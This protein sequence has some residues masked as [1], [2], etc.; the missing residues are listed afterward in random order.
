ME[1][2]RIVPLGGIPDLGMPRRVHVGF[3]PF[4]PKGEGLWRSAGGPA[5][6]RDRGLPRSLELAAPAPPKSRSGPETGPEALLLLGAFGLHAGSETPDAVGATV[7]L[8]RGT[9]LVRSFPLRNGVHYADADDRALRSVLPGDGSEVKTVG[10]CLVDGRM[11]RVDLLTI[12]LPAGTEFDRVVFH[13]EGGVSSFAIL[14]AA[15]VWEE[16][17][18][19][20]FRAGAG[21][22]SLADLGSVVRVRDRVRFGKALDQLESSLR[23]SEDL[24]EARSEALTFIAVVTAGRLESGA[25]RSLHRTQLDAARRFEAVASVEAL[26]D[27]ARE[28]LRSLVPELLS[29]EESAQDRQID[30]ALAILARSFAGPLSDEAV[31]GQVGLSTSHFRH[32]FREVTGQ[33]FHRYLVALRLEK[34]KAMLERQ[35]LGVGDVAEAVGFHNLA[36]FSRAFNQRFGA[37][38][39]SMRKGRPQG[40]PPRDPGLA[41]V[42][43]PS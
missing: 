1:G 14:E 31:A 13:D 42:R 43:A 3:L 33:P 23:A 27:A 4:E 39:T 25:P 10:C 37:S 18:T 19:C 8:M 28:I 17:A 38:P 20:P 21:G 16:P 24:D 5:G 30:R 9:R 32:L 15:L 34:A 29:A 6:H 12:D 7:R 11:V 2:K 26:L 36:H 40:A 22:V 41:G 35:A